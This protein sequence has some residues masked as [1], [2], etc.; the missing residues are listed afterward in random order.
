MAPYFAIW[1]KE[2]GVKLNIRYGDSAELAAQILEEGKN[3]PADLF[4]SQDAGSLGAV[5]E[6]GL[7]TPLPKDVAEGVPAKYIQ[8]NR[9][10]VG[11]TARVRVFAYA[12]DRVKVLP[13]SFTDL[14]KPIYKD[15]VA[16]A[17]TNASFQAF[18]TAAEI[19]AQVVMA[20]KVCDLG[21]M[22]GG[23]TRLSNVVFMGMGEP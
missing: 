4:I 12:P 10:W 15:Q 1:Q 20:A 16:I 2:S 14:S 5:A 11:L 7:L 13:T 22:P 17:P 21:E 19:T 3:S 8:G 6:Q 9:E 18:L 23:P